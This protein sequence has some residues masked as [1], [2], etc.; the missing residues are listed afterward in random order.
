MNK[1]KEVRNILKKVNKGMPECIATH[2]RWLRI[3]NQIQEV[4]PYIPKD[5]RVLDIVCVAG[6]NTVILKILRPDIT[7]L[8]IEPVKHEEWQYFKKEE[9]NFKVGNA[10]NLENKNESF[11]VVLSFGVMEHVRECYDSLYGK[12]EFKN[13]EFR[14]MQEIYRVLK[15]GGLNIIMSLP[16]KYSWTECLA[17]FK[18]ISAH[19]YKYTKKC[20]DKLIKMSGFKKIVIK[21][22][23]FIPAQVPLKNKHLLY[24]FNKFYKVLDIIDKIVNRL[25]PLNILSQSYFIVCK[26]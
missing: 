19:P 6:Y 21:K 20:I 2:L 25:Y 18:G 26:K 23:F 1:F 16:N 9:C 8:G 3:K 10:L 14:F 7:I 22:K 17:N 4:I 15:K 13:E 5:A 11:D 24:I 12:R